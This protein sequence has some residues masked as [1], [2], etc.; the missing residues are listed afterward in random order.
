MTNMPPQP[1]S[2]VPVTPADAPKG[3]PENVFKKK[4]L[5]DTV[6]EQTGEKR[7][8]VKKIIEAT[9]TVMSEN[10]VAQR[11]LAL[12]P[13]G[14]LRILDERVVQGAHVLKCKLRVPVDGAEEDDTPPYGPAADATN[15]SQ[16]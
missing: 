6:A 2:A 16:G 3:L 1:A 13:L 4:E 11:D 5:V 8:I 10:V 15:R 7:A 14:K 12:P 9:L